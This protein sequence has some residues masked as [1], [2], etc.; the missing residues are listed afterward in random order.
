MLLVLFN[1]DSLFKAHN[2]R[3][4]KRTFQNTKMLFLPSIKK[5]LTL[6]NDDEKKIFFNDKENCFFPLF[7]IPGGSTTTWAGEFL[8][9]LLIIVL[10]YLFNSIDLIIFCQNAFRARFEFQGTQRNNT[11]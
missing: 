4:I 2:I 10:L 5:I 11:L 6:F 1:F 7:F 9:R 3:N 8:K